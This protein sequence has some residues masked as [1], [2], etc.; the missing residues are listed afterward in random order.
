MSHLRLSSLRFL[1]YSSLRLPTAKPISKYSQKYSYMQSGTSIKQLSLSCV[2]TQQP[3]IQPHPPPPSADPNSTNRNADTKP[4]DAIPTAKRIPILGF[5]YDFMKLP[6]TNL[7]RLVEHRVKQFGKI[8]REKFAPGLPDMLFVLDPE[9][10]AA[11]FRAD[12]RY[13]RRPLMAEWIAVR[14]ELNIPLGLVLT[15]V[16]HCA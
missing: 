3:Q 8:F 7:T 15:Y 13:P 5:S 12:G 4:F 1:Q 9:D 2:Y 6:P 16:R 14:K 11:V 10:V